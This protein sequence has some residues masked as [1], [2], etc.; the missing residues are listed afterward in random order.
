MSERLL[1]HFEPALPLARQMAGDFL[2]ALF[3]PRLTESSVSISPLGGKR[4]Y[5]EKKTKKKC[6][7]VCG[8]ATISICEKGKEMALVSRA[9]RGNP[10][11]R[12]VVVPFLLSY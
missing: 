9:D 3:F 1:L 2:T 6:V 5:K 10:A 12:A 4:N 11:R 7:C 8:G